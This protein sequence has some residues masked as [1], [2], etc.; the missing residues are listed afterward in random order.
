M[1]TRMKSRTIETLITTIALLTRTDS[2][3]PRTKSTVRAATISM[4]GTL[5]YA[6]ER[7]K[8]VQSTWFLE[9]TSWTPDR[10]VQP[11]ARW[12]GAAIASG[13]LIIRVPGALA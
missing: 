11:E 2:L 9:S 5:R 3:I 10:G 4:A 1:P 12:S 13:M 7:A 6:V 8:A